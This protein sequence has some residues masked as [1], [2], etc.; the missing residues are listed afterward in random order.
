MTL[1]LAILLTLSLCATTAFA[2]VGNIGLFDDVNGTDC[3]H[4][5]TVSGLQAIYV[6]HVNGVA[7]ASD[8][9][10]PIPSCWTGGSFLS[11]TAVYPVTIGSSPT[12]VSIGYGACTP[13]P[14]HILTIN[15][16]GQGTG[17]TCCRMTIQANVNVPSGQIEIVDCGGSL[18]Q[19]GPIGG[20]IIINPDGSCSCDVATQNTT[21]G[22]LKSLYETE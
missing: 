22:A 6:V 4:E 1:R 11:D 10:A 12:G 14:N 5:D 9:A 2:Q 8:F 21:W 3:E 16:F 15:V 17:D 7:A 18:F 20:T 19:I 13:S